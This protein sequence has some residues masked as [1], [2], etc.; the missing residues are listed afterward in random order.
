[1]RAEPKTGSSSSDGSSPQKQDP[2]ERRRLQNRLSQRNHRRKIRDRIAKLQERVIANE[3]R[4]TA[5]LNGWDQT[6]SLPFISTRH[7]HS[8]Y[9]S[10]EPELIFGSQDHSP[11]STEPSTPFFPSYSFPAPIYSTDLLA[12]SPEYSGDPSYHLESVCMGSAVPKQVSQG[13]QIV[14]N[15]QDMEVFHDPWGTVRTGNAIMGDSGS[16]NQP[17]LYIAT[18]S[19][20]PHI[21][22]ALEMSSSQS[23][24]IVLVSPESLPSLQTGILG[25]NSRPMNPSGSMDSLGCNAIDCIQQT[26]LGMANTTYQCQP[27][28]NAYSLFTPQML[29]RAW[30]APPGLYIPPCA[31]H[32]TPNLPDDSFSALHV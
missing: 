18:E 1:M 17:N 11:Q 31:L 6:Y 2:L 9:P 29:S 24:I 16:I 10:Q 32:N 8:P 7:S 19:L 28:H 27:Q 25:T 22:H 15:D 23:K 21:L 20:L 13:M 26:P 14:G 4:A 5:A 3:L 12:Q 30:T